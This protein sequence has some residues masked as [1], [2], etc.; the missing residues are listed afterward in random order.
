MTIYALSSGPGLSGVAV[1]RISG[2][3]TSNVIKLLTG[4]DLPQPRVATLRKINKIN[5]SE[6]IDEGL[7]LW[8]PG[9]ESYTGEDMAEIQ[10]HGSKAVVDALHSSLSDIQNCRLAEP[11]EFTKLAFQNGKRITLKE[12]GFEVNEN[13][14]ENLEISSKASE[15]PI[16][17]ELVR[18]RVQV[19]AFKE[20]V[21]DDILAS[22]KKLGVVLAKTNAGQGYT[23]YYMG[24]F[25]DYKN[26]LKYRSKLFDNGLIDCF[27]VG[28]FQNKIITSRE[29]L[30]LLGK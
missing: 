7:I 5:T 28:E 16:D 8:F 21:P 24:D 9:P 27:I 3:H 30:N 12:A 13:F 19:G 22:F 20:K 17:P 29:A 1:I 4:K 2:A 11:G 14:K 25:M 18:F 15:N 6:L 10:V 26:V 23:K